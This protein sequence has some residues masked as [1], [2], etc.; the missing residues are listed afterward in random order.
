MGNESEPVG[1]LQSLRWLF[2]WIWI[3]VLVPLEVQGCLEMWSGAVGPRLTV[4]CV[5]MG[6]PNATRRDTSVCWSTQIAP[7]F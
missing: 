2:R 7:Q 1:V 4:T 3:V 5:A 6:L